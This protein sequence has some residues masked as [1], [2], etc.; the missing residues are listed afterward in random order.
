M[1]DTG[2]LRRLHVVLH[3]L[4]QL[5]DDIQAD[6]LDRTVHAVLNAA[7]TIFLKLSLKEKAVRFYGRRNPTRSMSLPNLHHLAMYNSLCDED[8][9]M[10]DMTENIE[11]TD[12]ASIRT[13]HSGFTTDCHLFIIGHELQV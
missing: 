12:T 9:E 3:D 6:D 13:V 7:S 11:G 10:T 4:L 5:R 2:V 8:C 1:L